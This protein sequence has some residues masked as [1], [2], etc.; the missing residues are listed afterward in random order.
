MCGPEEHGGEE[1]QRRLSVETIDLRQPDQADQRGDERGEGKPVWGST[2]CCK[3]LHR[4][5]SAPSVQV[6]GV[7]SALCVQAVG[8]TGVAASRGR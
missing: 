2:R 5:S 4:I 1:A 6:H 8:R 3:V 7:G